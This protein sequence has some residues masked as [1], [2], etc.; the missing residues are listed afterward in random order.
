MVLIA[1]V[2]WINQFQD[3]PA[4]AAVGKTHWVVRLGRQ[5]A[6]T[7]YGLLLA[8]TYLLLILGVL[9]VRV[10]PFALL[11]LLTAP[12]ALKAYRVARAHYDHPR[13]LTPANAMTIQIHLLTG[14]LLSLG[15]LIQG[16]VTRLV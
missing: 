16:I 14:L 2:L 13:E 11:G 12:L 5:R 10:S 1:L 4:D 15:Y 9:L 7:A 8:A 3:M 6:A